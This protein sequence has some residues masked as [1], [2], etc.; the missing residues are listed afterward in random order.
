MEIYNFD[1]VIKDEQQFINRNIL[2]PQWPFRLLIIGPS[3]CGKT[4]LLLN[5]L[6][7]YLVYNKVYIYAKDLD[8]TKYRYLEEY[9]QNVEELLNGN[10]TLTLNLLNLVTPKMKLLTS[11]H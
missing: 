8:E 5:L 4:N 3:G 10:I 7:E 11:I 1:D 6:T 9:Y 2:A